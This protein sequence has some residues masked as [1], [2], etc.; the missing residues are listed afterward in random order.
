MICGKVCLHPGERFCL[1]ADLPFGLGFPHSFQ[2]FADVRAGLQ[3][4]AFHE[5]DAI[6]ELGRCND[7]FITLEIRPQCGFD[8]LGC[9]FR[10]ANA[11]IAP[12]HGQPLCQIQHEGFRA[13]AFSLAIETMQLARCCFSRLSPLSGA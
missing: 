9:Q 8:P 12:R 10:A 5:H 2:Q 6:D 3:I 4:E 7:G 13:A 1:G 11:I